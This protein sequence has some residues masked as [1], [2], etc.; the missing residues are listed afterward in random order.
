MK[1]YF[2]FLITME[3]CLGLKCYSDLEG[4][5]WTDC[6]QRKGFRTCFT[7]FDMNGGVIAR[8]CSTKDKIFH[9]ECENHMMGRTSEK[10]CYCSYFLCNH[11]RQL[12]TTHWMF[13]FGVLA[14][15]VKRI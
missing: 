10:F 6:D 2:L 15:I 7:K 4:L 3:A 1:K 5:Q 12:R 9:I 11:G 14:V 8:G 13:S